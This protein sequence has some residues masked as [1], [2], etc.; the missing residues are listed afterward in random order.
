MEGMPLSEQRELD[1]LVS[2]AEKHLPRELF[3]WEVLG[4]AGNP[5]GFPVTALRL[6]AQDPT[7]PTF[8]LVG[9]V[10]GL[11]RIGAQVVLAFLQRLAVQAEWDQALQ[12]LLSQMRVVSIPIL[13]PVGIA[14]QTRSN[15]NGVDLMRNAPVES[16]ER[17]SPWA[18]YRGHHWGP[19]L[20]WYRG[21]RGG[22]LEPENQW[23]CQWV[24]RELFPSRVAVSIDVHSGF[25]ALD[26][27]WF[28]YAR[29]H[30]AFSDLGR[31]FRLKRLLDETHRY[32]IYRFEPQSTMY[33]VHGDVW[34][35]LYDR[36]QG[37]EEGRVFLPLTL[38]M[39][40]WSWLRKNYLQAFRLQA[41]FHPLKAH[42]VR[43]TLRRHGALLEFLLRA[44]GS[45]DRWAG[46]D[47]ELP[48]EARALWKF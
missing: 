41:L 20:P 22:A 7:L 14:Q 42:R 17:S 4:Q 46:P 27:V 39:G 10:H 16:P 31:A 34:D 35:Y 37:R 2:R 30:R 8:A 13:N 26:R 44:T 24:E 28:P 48:I 29:E 9:G 12:G 25:G 5:P 1:L 43:R 45:S 18:L 3:G 33:T 19:W 23:L 32:H 6:G 21:K 11:E 36:F 47:Q 40:S 38:E 15:G